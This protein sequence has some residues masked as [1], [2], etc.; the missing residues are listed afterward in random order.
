MQPPTGQ[1]VEDLVMVLQSRG[2]NRTDTGLWWSAAASGSYVKL[3]DFMAEGAPLEPSIDA[4]DG[5]EWLLLLRDS[6]GLTLHAA[7][8]I[9][10]SDSQVTS[11][12]LT[13]IPSTWAFTATAGAGA[14]VAQG[15]APPIDWSAL[16]HDAFGEPWA[17]GL[18]DTL[19]ITALAPGEPV[20]PLAPLDR[21]A[22]ASWSREVTGDDN[23]A[24]GWT[25][26][27][28]GAVFTGF[29]EG[30]D[31]LVSLHCS[32]CVHPTPLAAVR[33]RAQAR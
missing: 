30:S 6:D 19:R 23:A 20:D 3:T 28:D 11:V 17:S 12:G 25:S 21:V 32:G 4:T 27:P 9:V 14:D 18:A 2:P 10:A 24:S 22:T 29:D 7:T 13:A 8:L 33:V 1:R 15:A 26:S 16:T 5:S 31:W